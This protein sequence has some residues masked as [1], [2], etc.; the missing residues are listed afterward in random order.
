MPNIQLQMS[1]GRLFAY[2]LPFNARTC[3]STDRVSSRRRLGSCRRF[4]TR[5]D[6]SRCEKWLCVDLRRRAAGCS[7]APP[8]VY[9]TPSAERGSRVFPRIACW[10]L[11]TCLHSA[12]GVPEA[13]SERAR[14]PCGSS[15]RTPSR[16]SLTLLSPPGRWHAIRRGLISAGASCR[17]RGVG[18][19][20]RRSPGR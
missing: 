15:P 5:L 18:R 1:Q 11:R 6:A 17:G 19:G 9:H 20:S 7:Q 16:P 8:A 14:G 13:A 10:P 2:L 4:S 3:I 12:W